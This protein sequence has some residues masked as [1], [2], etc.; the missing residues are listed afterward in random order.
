MWNLKIDFYGNIK[1]V[2][3]QENQKSYQNDYKILIDLLIDVSPD[4]NNSRMLRNL[5]SF[6]FIL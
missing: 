6:I 4:F 3:S 1:N 2:S 5:C